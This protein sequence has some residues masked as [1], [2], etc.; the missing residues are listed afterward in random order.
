MSNI[1]TFSL[2]EVMS[3]KIAALVKAGF[4][5]SK[6]D[7]AKE[8][9]RYLFEQK[10][11]LKI[12]AAIE[13]YKEGKASIGRAA[14]VA[15]MSTPDFIDAMAERGIKRISPYNKKRMQKGIVVLKKVR[16]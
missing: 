6:S 1:E 13:M 11:N 7:V 15:E 8:A 9:L 10:P 3:E 12:S 16:R 5:T 4:Y 2:P 14:E